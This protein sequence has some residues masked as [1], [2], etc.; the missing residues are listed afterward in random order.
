MCKICAISS[1]GATIGGAGGAGTTVTLQNL[2]SAHLSV[3]IVVGDGYR[4]AIRILDVASD[5]GVRFGSR[6]APGGS[7]SGLAGALAVAGRPTL[8]ARVSGSTN[9]SQS[10]FQ[11]FCFLRLNEFLYRNECESGSL[12]S[13]MARSPPTVEQCY[14]CATNPNNHHLNYS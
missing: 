9:Q 8:G 1:F 13:T 11:L 6:Q 5:S 4:S 2:I 10:K 12:N 3:R 14:D 7:R